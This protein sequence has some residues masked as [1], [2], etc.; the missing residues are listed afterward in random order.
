MRRRTTPLAIVLALLTALATPVAAESE[1][2]REKSSRSRTKARPVA[3][4]Q[5]PVP[6]IPLP[7]V[8][9]RPEEEAP[10]PAP[11][12][13]R[14]PQR[15]GAPNQPS[16]TAP[17]SASDDLLPELS[18]AGT[19]N[20][21]TSMSQNIGR[22][23]FDLPYSYPSLREQ[24]FAGLNSA[25]RD[26]TSLFDNP[27]FATIIDRSQLNE[28]DASD[29]FRA[30][31]YEVG[32]LMQATARG[33]ASPFLRGLTGQ[34]VL[35]L[36]DGV[37]LNNST[38][39]AGPNQYF[40]LIDPGMVDRVEI[41][42]GPEGVVWGA[43]A[44]GGVIN[45]VSRSASPFRGNYG[46]PTFTEYFGTADTSSYSRG[47]IEG[48][49]GNSGV[50]AGGSYLNVNDL[51]RGGS[52]GRQPFTNFHQYAGD[53]KYNYLL[54]S[55]W[56]LTADVQHFE[57]LDLPRSDRF[58]PFVLGPPANTPRPTWFNPQQRDMA[59]LRL[60]GVAYSGLFDAASSTVSYQ[61]NKEAV[62]E[63]RSATRTDQGEFDVNT[64]G[65]DLVFAKDLE[66]FGS[67]TYGCD[68][69]YDHIDSFRNQI[70]PQTGVSVPSTPQFPDGSTY[71]RMGTFLSWRVPLVDRLDAVT[72]VRYENANAQAV[73]TVNN[74]R[75]PFKRNYRDWITSAGLI[76]SAT[77]NLNIVGNVSEGYRAP[78]L[79][80]LTAD[81]TVLQNGTDLPSLDVDPEHPINYEIG[82]KVDTPRLRM[83]VFQFWTDLRNQI[84]RQ[85]VDANGNPVPDVIVNGVRVPGSSNFVR[86]NFDCYMYGTE[87]AGEYLL[88]DGWSLYGNYWY[89]YG[90]DR[91]RSEP[92]SRVPPMQ[93][94]VGFRWRDEYDRNWF[95]IFTWLVDRQD[96]YAAQN[97]VDSRFIAGGTPGYATLNM[98]VG[99]NFGE[100]LNHRVSMSLENI[101]DKAYRVLGSGVDGPGINAVFG[102]EYL[103]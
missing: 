56:M 31:Q 18:G 59:Y 21:L 86:A 53:V 70:N 93:G 11:N 32:V 26:S 103:H 99:K 22:N 36:V 27:S 90:L 51:D 88:E 29:M 94:I 83:Q 97:N 84:L 91:S 76:Y 41:V 67:L 64:F 7:P 16:D 40:N 68:I 34:Q 45:V 74:V 2:S 96:R 25:T 44:I 20:D 47:N 78:N 48:W 38:Y 65:Y 14:P 52:L 73:P 49:V 57:Q 37:R 17:E 85:A 82:F 61:R 43:D 62:T 28:R 15:G 8:E 89:T 42:R 12:E 98:R 60:Q 39:R 30:L 1:E 24:D 13:P 77:D 33:Q 63:I 80:D 23:P 54:S 58:P 79:D 6:E 35:L 10:A 9:V 81:N 69:Y 71:D 87:L 92:L 102:Y 55:D 95:D 72:G 66:S 19:E 3:R 101:T 5:E 50:F 46:F 100:C 75:V 4:L